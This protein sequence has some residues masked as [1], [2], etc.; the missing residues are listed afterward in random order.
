M[1]FSDE[2]LQN[3]KE[4]VRFSELAL[5]FVQLKRSGKNFVGL[6]PF[7]SEKS[8]SFFV[9]DEEAAYH[10]FGCGKK[11]S[12]FNFVME[13]R[14]FTFP[15]AVRYLAKQAGVV[16]PEEGVSA[17]QN[18]H[19]LELRELA[20]AACE[21]FQTALFESPT[22]Q[23][24]A[25]SRG[26]SPE[27]IRAYHVGYAPN[28]WDFLETRVR[29]RIQARG[30]LKE[31]SETRLR[32]CLLELGLLKSKQRDESPD[33]EQKSARVYDAFRD[34]LIF[35][36]LRSD[37]RPIAFGGRT[38]SKEDGVPKYINSPESPLYSKR[39]T[40]FGVPQALPQAR[41][42][43]HVYLVEGYLDVL[44]LY[45]VGVTAVVA[46]CG[47]AVTSQHADMLKRFADAVTVLFDGD[48]AGKKAAAQCFPVFLNSGLD[49]EVVFL[50]DG[51][52]PDSAARAMPLAE[53]RKILEDTRRSSAAVF[54]DALV[55]EECDDGALSPAACGRIAK[56]YA[57]SVATVRNAVE[58]EF[59]LRLGAQRLDVSAQA[60]DALVR[61]ESKKLAPRV[62]S[63]EGSSDPYS[64]ESAVPETGRGGYAVARSS[65]DGRG[66]SASSG[67]NA[68][69]RSPSSRSSSSRTPSSRTKE[70]FD[71]LYRQLVIAVLC[72]PEI[73]AALLGASELQTVEPELVE[74]KERVFGFVEEFRSSELAGVFE[75][76]EQLKAAAAGNDGSG[77]DPLRFG[78]APSILA[79]LAAHG[80]A[81]LGLLEEAFRQARTGGAR[82]V[83]LVRESGE[84]ALRLS[85]QLEVERL[86]QAESQQSEEGDRLQLA[87]KKL[88]QKRGI[89]RQKVLPG[90]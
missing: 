89:H 51:H 43:R 10:C 67:R 30:V 85:R 6:C 64:A 46:T 59:L 28:A 1:A 40:L 78:S 76:C 5:E 38:L 60:F 45:Q 63:T 83:E 62:T 8:P 17:Q 77:P 87:Q 20:L 36:I 72:E 19:V 35:P 12:I 4:R 31:M 75:L 24:Y 14:G 49:V 26:L 18:T 21:V 73:A 80:L 41:R 56:R 9:R 71:R 79:L 82:P 15:E 74:T 22:A 66:A 3:I 23:A 48:A 65:R 42:D 88:E 27:L 2:I 25:S 53:L 7:H 58:K 33:G 52:D 44:S 57:T 68:S 37:G 47:T 34:R 55:E 54:L 39:R 16:L 86:Q 90:A 32:E 50:P 70:Q 61:E 69:S 29:A 11:G 81:E 13:M 84:A